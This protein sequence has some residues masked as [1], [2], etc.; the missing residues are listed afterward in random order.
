MTKRYRLEEFLND[1]QADVGTGLLVSRGAG[2][3]FT[4]KQQ[5]R[6]GKASDGTPVLPFGGIGGKLEV[7]ETPVESLHRESVEEVGADISI[8]ELQGK[9]IL[10]DA[11][12]IEAISISTDLPNEP[13]PSIIFKSAR[14]EQGRKPY[15]YVLIYLGIFETNDIRP[16]DDPALVEMDKDLLIRLAEHPAV[17]VSQFGTEGG[18]LTSRIELPGNGIL[19]PIGTAVAAVRCLKAKAL[20]SLLSAEAKRLWSGF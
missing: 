7:G 17:T 13:L 8:V 9:T 2:F 20:E 16:I 15:T 4:M 18:R 10:M 3:C 1:P 14:A 5:S 19:K 11:D 12:T 6:W